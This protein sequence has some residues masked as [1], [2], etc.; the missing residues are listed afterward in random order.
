MML[1]FLKNKTKYGICH[2]LYIILSEIYIYI[3]SK[4]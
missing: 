1:I 4:S 2:N 3:Y